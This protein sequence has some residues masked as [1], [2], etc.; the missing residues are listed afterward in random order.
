L[1]P[2]QGGLLADTNTVDEPSTVDSFL[3]E[4]SDPASPPESQANHAEPDAKPE[5][6]VEHPNEPSH[7][8]WMEVIDP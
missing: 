8:V 5:A 2:T 6:A 1:D 4:S 3:E 7:T